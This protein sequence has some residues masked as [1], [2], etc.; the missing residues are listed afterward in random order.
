MKPTDLLLRAVEFYVVP[1]MPRSALRDELH[2]ALY[3]RRWDETS[4][5]RG[6]RVRQKKEL[7]HVTYRGHVCQYRCDDFGELELPALNGYMLYHSPRP[8][9]VVVDGGAYHGT[10]TIL[11]ARMVGP[12]GKVI[13]FEPDGRNRE[14]LRENVELNDLDNVIIV[15]KGLWSSERRMAFCE[16]G[17]DFSALSY[18]DLHCNVNLRHEVTG[19]VEV[20][21][22]DNEIERLDIDRLDFLKMDIEGSEIEAVKGARDVLT[23]N[24]VKVAIASYHEVE[25]CKTCFALEE[26]LTSLGYRTETNFPM[27]ITTYAHK[28]SAE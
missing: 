4:I 28:P 1:L 27:H 7:A 24:D 17:E 14:R 25:G 6:F 5:Y 12:E 11:A 26:L 19:E 16:Y 2:T 22:L 15:P 18:E 20:V 23:N 21:S 10:F 8:G 9:D 3:S 13:A